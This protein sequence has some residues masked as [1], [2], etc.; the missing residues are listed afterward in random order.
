MFGEA[1]PSHFF[2]HIE[3]DCASADLVIV[4]GTS[5]KV[6]PVNT[7]IR[8]VPKDVPQI[9]INRE[10]VARGHGFDSELLG[11]CDKVRL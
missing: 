10:V 2:Q 6:A 8:R 7:I 1:L 9:L 5:L 3:D 4:I 11:D